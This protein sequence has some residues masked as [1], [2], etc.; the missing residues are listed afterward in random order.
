MILI[1][2]PPLIKNSEFTL[3]YFLYVT[4]LLQQK[5]LKLEYRVTLVLTLLR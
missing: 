3:N 1:H 2:A 5:T 4:L